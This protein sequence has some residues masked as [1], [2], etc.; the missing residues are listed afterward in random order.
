MPKPRNLIDSFMT[1]LMKD[2]KS[3]VDSVTN[4]TPQVSSAPPQQNFKYQDQINIISGSEHDQNKPL[5]RTDQEHIRI[6]KGSDK[7]QLNS[8]YISDKDQIEISTKGQDR[9]T[10]GKISK[11]IAKISPSGSLSKSQTL[12]FLWF[13]E[14][15]ETGVFNKPEIE[16][17][18]SMPYITIRKAIQKL[19]T[20]GILEL[21][22]DTCQ[23]IY[24]YK[25]NSAKRVKL[26]KNISIGAGLYQDQNNI[27]TS[28]LISSSS[29]LR[30][31]TT[32]QN[33]DSEII[34]I[35]E[36]VMSTDPEYAYWNDQQVTPRQISTWKQ[37][38]G[39]DLQ[40]I[41]NNLC[42]VRWQIVH[43][44][45]EI[46][47]G[48][49]Q[50]IYGIMKK[51]GGTV[52]KPAGYKSLAQLDLEYFE[53]WKNQ[54]DEKANKIKRLKA[55][56]VKSS[57]EPKITEILSRPD[58]ENEHLQSALEQIHSKKRKQGIISIL[59]SGNPLDE[60]S[61]SVLR[62]HLEMILTQEAIKE[63]AISEFPKEVTD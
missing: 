19:E 33:C 24:E 45:A 52:N 25:L 12:V 46:K 41:M 37:E 43:Q 21:I 16:R 56:A 10:S 53:N 39:L 22:Y 28:S 31:T 4:D 13:K 5:S 50:L 2:A 11:N 26:A 36:Q 14:R 6:I 58:L 30:E 51:N 23:K 63:L 32:L 44:N 62:G 40:T 27:G 61:E 1:G 29:L 3:A 57:I 17:D 55:E 7:D 20:V 47:K 49:A 18:L 35:I 59:E 9:S 54:R 38:F 8:R 34:K 42:Y 60:K 15:G 48:P